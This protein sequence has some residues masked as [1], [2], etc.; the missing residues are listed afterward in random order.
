M[1]NETILVGDAG[2]TNVRFALAHVVDGRLA[3][4]EPWKR[5]GSDFP[6]FDDAL[7]AFLR[8]TGARPTGAAFGFAGAVSHG[9]VS[10]LHRAWSVDRAALADKLGVARVVV[11]NDFF[12]MARGAAEIPFSEMDEIAPGQADEEGTIAVGGPGTGFGIAVLRRAAHG[13]VVVAGEGGHQTFSPLTDLEW[14]VAENL[15][16][17]DIYV[18]NEIIAAGAGFDETRAALAAAMGLPDPKSSQADVIAAAGAGDAFALEF[19]RLRA[20]CV[21]TSMGN[22][23]LSSCATGGIRLA[24]GVSQHLSPWL[25]EPGVLARFHQRG[26]RTDLLSRIPIHLIAGQ[27]AP[28][29]GAAHLWRD[30]QARGWL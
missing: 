9:R 21:M 22:L 30:E 25:R 5:P 3:L 28:L 19:C 1:G 8:E 13:W 26:P 4:S 16:E 12:A 14:R 7:D 15:R 10:L 20:R 6:T 2:G 23:A 18:S 11:V 29:I 24:G 17:R 27:S